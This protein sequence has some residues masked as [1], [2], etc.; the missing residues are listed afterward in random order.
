MVNGETKVVSADLHKSNIVAGDKDVLCKYEIDDG[1]YK[2][3]KIT[4]TDTAPAGFTYAEVKSYKDKK[5]YSDESAGK[6]STSYILDSNAVVYVKYKDD[7]Y[8]ILTGKD[9]AGW[10]DKLKTLTATSVVLTKEKDG[11]TVVKGAALNLGTNAIPASTATYGVITS[12]IV[13]AKDNKAEFTIWN[14]TEYIDVVTKSSV[15]GLNKFDLVEYQANTDGTYDI[16][17][18]AAASTKKAIVGY[19]KTSGDIKFAAA[20]GSGAVDKV[21]VKDTQVIFVNTD[22]D[23]DAKDAGIIG[24]EI[25]VSDKPVSNYNTN[26][27][28]YDDDTND[29]DLT[30][31]VIDTVNAEYAAS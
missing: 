24:E 25:A 20:D 6:N 31:L 23:V 19:S 10:G 9:V 15:S 21:V 3:T 1:V 7:K 29:T 27:L 5:L 16:T 22:K 14:G 4:S 18:K 2:F 26:V 11:M 12:D 28:Y 30:V 8:S 17:Q 13:S